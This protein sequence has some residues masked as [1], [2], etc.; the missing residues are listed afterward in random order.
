MVG[1]GSR[2]LS[3]NHKTLLDTL[4]AEGKISNK[5]FSLYLENVYGKQ[6]S[7]KSALMI[8]GILKKYMGGPK[9]HFCKVI[10]ETYWAINMNKFELRAPTK[11]FPGHKSF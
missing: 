11:K 4:K 3:D 10:D 7:Y 2:Q 9:F 6:T 1:L 5:V 8:G